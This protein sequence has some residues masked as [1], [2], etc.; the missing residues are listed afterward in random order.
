MKQPDLFGEIPAAKAPPKSDTP[1]LLAMDPDYVTPAG[2]RLA[3]PVM[4][5]SVYFKSGQRDQIKGLPRELPSWLN[6]PNH[7]AARDYLAGYDWQAEQ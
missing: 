5:K 4:Q 2:A 7:K 6:R 3:L 1:M